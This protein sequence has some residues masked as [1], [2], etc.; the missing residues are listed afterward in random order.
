MRC[1]ICQRSI[2]EW[3]PAY[4][5]DDHTPK[6]YTETKGKGYIDRFPLCG[7]QCSLV[8]YQKQKSQDHA[9]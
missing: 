9:N 3:D 1:I 6:Y 4:L 7:P 2:T 8:H 5:A